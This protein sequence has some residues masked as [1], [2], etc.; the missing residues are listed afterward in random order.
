MALGPKRHLR[1]KRTMISV[2]LNLT[3]LIAQEA[4]SPLAPLPTALNKLIRPHKAVFPPL[5]QK[6]QINILSRSTYALS[7]KI[8][9][10]TIRNM[11]TRSLMRAISVSITLACELVSE[12]KGGNTTA[13]ANLNLEPS[14]KSIRLKQGDAT[15]P[16][17]LRQ[18]KSR[19]LLNMM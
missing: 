11:H 4:G 3:Q 19:G 9:C 16:V 17:L 14:P 13:K 7:V 5:G 15:V 2:P 1:R 8:S 6:T 18:A 10:V 12:E